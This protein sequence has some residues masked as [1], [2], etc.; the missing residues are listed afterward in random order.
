MF[1]IYIFK[2]FC[3]YTNLFTFKKAVARVYKHITKKNKIYSSSMASGNMHVVNLLI[4]F[5]N[6]YCL[7]I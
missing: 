7:A 1:Y 4:L 5:K 2:D 3:I 6:N